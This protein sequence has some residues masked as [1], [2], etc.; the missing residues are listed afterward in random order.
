M[1][2]WKCAGRYVLASAATLSFGS[3]LQAGP[4]E[5]RGF[6]TT[7]TSFSDSKTPYNQGITRK[8]RVTEET[9]L[10]LNLS[11]SLTS[12][13][14]LAAQILGRSGQAD[15]AAKIDWAFVTYEPDQDYS[16]TLGKQKI[17]MWMI[18]EYIDVGRLYPWVVPPEEVYGLFNLKSFTGA[19]GVY[20]LALGESTLSLSPYGGDV[21]LESSPNDPDEYSKIRGN[22]MFGVS[23]NWD[24]QPISVRM[25]Y[26]R[27]R[28]N[29][30]LGPNIQ[31]GERN[32]EIYTFG[33]KADFN[34]LMIMAEYAATEDLDEDKFR[35][36]ADRLESQAA[37]AA[38]A[39]A[40]VLLGQ[41]AL[42]RQRIGG[43]RAYYATLG[44]NLGESFL[45]H[46]T[47]AAA[48]RP[49][50]PQ[51]SRDQS[52]VALGLNYDINTDSVVKVE[53]KRVMVPDDSQGLFDEKPLKDEAMIYRLSYSLVF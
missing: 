3:S 27:A 37:S 39:D 11:K 35:D 51:L 34:D 16:L 19:S 6:L 14:R 13:W 20:K 24:L 29:L 31:F 44:K 33:F 5:W 12:E 38:A 48:K 25:A 21:V 53:G 8:A 50:A 18:S 10:G 2:F 22:N 43:S 45:L 46:L 1:T 40:P 47:Y 52:S 32:Y 36:E 41:S 7:G 49:S 26:N 28:W 17:P 42:L 15:G 30:N 9:F 4:L 23:V